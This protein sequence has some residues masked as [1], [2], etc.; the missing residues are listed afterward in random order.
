MI[1][2]RK[3][4]FAYPD[5]TEAL[6]DIDVKFEPEHISAVLGESGSGKT[7]LMRCI[8]GF[9]PAKSGRI[10]IDGTDVARLEKAELRRRLGTV[11][12]Q[13]YLFPHLT[14][15]RNLTLAPT[16][17]GGRAEAEVAG[18]A[19]DMLER[20]GISE[21]AEQYPAQISGG[22]AQRAAIARALMLQPDYVLLDEPTSALDARTTAE[23]AEWLR[24][25]Q[26]ST[27]FIIVTH[28]VPFAR[29][30]AGRGVLISKGRVVGQGPLAEIIA[31]ILPGQDPSAGTRSSEDS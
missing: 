4:C 16:I 10:L 28:D 27:Q 29:M 15:L 5:G 14:V 20:F 31:H 18:E 2:I 25:L 13:L 7:T 12:Q 6:I 19:R 26:A 23:F 21:L 3:V 8:S 9:L 11:F 17:V 1:E 30:V 22:Q 24:E